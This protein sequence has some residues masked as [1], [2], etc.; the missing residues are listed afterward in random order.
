MTIDELQWF[1]VLAE[2]EHVTRAADRLHITQPTLSR[3]LRRLEKRVGTPL[4]DRDNQRLRL[5]EYGRVFRLHAQRALDEL[6]VAQDHITALVA[7]PPETLVLGFA[8]SLGTW[9]VPELLGA[10][11]RECPGAR[12]TLLQDTIEDTLARL[13]DGT[14]EMIVISPR[15]ADH[16]IDWLPIC[17]ERLELVVPADSPLAGRTSV[18]LAE[19]AG[20]RVITMRCSTGLRQVARAIWRRAG[21]TPAVVAEAN[22]ITTVKSL[23]ASGLGISLLPAGDRTPP[24]AGVRQI[25]VADSGV[26]RPVGLAWDSGRTATTAARCFRQFVSRYASRHTLGEACDPIP[27]TD[28]SGP[29]ETRSAGTSQGL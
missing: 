20:E 7:S 6:D 15:P 1:L 11:R 12:F 18:H 26:F 9:L 21:I 14:V 25:P 5:N 27:P 16:R 17:D 10:Y 3:A 29:T 24:P 23:V 28:L 4:F 2:T 8:H 13:M 19:L 22:D